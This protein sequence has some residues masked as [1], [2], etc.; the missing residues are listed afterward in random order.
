MPIHI[1]TMNKNQLTQKTVP[2]GGYV[3]SIFHRAATTHFNHTHPS[4]YKVTPTPISVQLSF[5]RR[6]AATKAVLKVEDTKLGARTSTLHVTMLQRR[7]GKKSKANNN[8]I[9]GK[10]EEEEPLE[11]KVTGYITVTP[12]TAEIGTTT[13]TD[14]TIH[15]PPVAGTK[16]N[17]AVDLTAL[18]TTGQDGAWTRLAKIS[19]F[20]R[21]LQHVEAYVPRS[22]NRRGINDQW[23]RFRPG[24]GGGD[25]GD[26]GAR[27]TDE[28]VMYLID[29]F[30]MALEGLGKMALSEAPADGDL[31]EV[32]MFWFPTVT[33][34]VDVKKRL[35]A[36]SGGVEWLYS[37]IVN[38]VIRD[39]RMDTHVEVVD[40]GGEVV[41][42]ASQ[43]ALIMSAMRNVGKRS[44]SDAGG[45]ARL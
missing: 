39:G 16:P 3:T 28:S 45:K 17:G 23:A 40:E 27:W 5:I 6:N 24:G 31:G 20:R 25:G 4:L 37:R 13:N 15:P 14:W 10:E 34:G 7:E 36:G 30:P 12:S 41:A 9:E 21:A 19:D 8:N 35:P 18:A 33:M 44:L 32:P 42:L 43:V 26:K 2:H 29:L 1:L 38:K 11:I 22:D